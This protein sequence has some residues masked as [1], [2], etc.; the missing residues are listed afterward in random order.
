MF[1]PLASRSIFVSSVFTIFFGL[2]QQK[3]FPE[4]G[5]VK[6]NFTRFF[7][8]S[9]TPNKKTVSNKVCNCYCQSYFW[10]VFHH[11]CLKINIIA[12]NQQYFF[13]RARD[14]K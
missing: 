7:H 10:P 4:H 14:S 9:G 13:T 2:N 6:N 5:K 3:I 12:L 1:A 11:S 8:P